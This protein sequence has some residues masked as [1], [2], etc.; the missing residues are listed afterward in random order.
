MGCS[1]LDYS[2]AEELEAGMNID[3][4]IGENHDEARKEAEEK[5]TELESLRIQLEKQER[6]TSLRKADSHFLQLQLE[7]KD[8][9]LEE[10]SSL[11]EAVEKRQGELERENLALRRELTVFREERGEERGII[12][13]NTP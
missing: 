4:N 9:L 10:V 6:T 1:K 8:K 7:D 13:R 3:G 2:L 12:I 11:L 5:S